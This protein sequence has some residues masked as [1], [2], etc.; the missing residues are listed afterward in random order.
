MSN[1]AGWKVRCNV[2]KKN[3]NNI[4]LGRKHYEEGSSEGFKEW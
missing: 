3:N 1:G 4:L 2:N